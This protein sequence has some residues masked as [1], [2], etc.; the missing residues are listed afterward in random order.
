M[1]KSIHSFTY[2][3]GSIVYFQPSQNIALFYSVPSAGPGYEITL[4][5]VIQS[6]SQASIL[7]AVPQSVWNQSFAYIVITVESQTSSVNYNQML[8]SYNTSGSFTLSGLGW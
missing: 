6:N 4:N 7:W 1:R 8:T 2:I 3:I 5:P